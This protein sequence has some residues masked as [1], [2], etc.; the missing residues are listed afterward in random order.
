MRRVI[1]SVLL[2]L[3]LLEGGLRVLLGNFGQSKVLQRSDDAEICLELKPETQLVYTGWRAR[4]APSNMI[5]NSAGFRG[6]ELEDKEQDGPLRMVVLG[7]SF[8][9]GQGVDYEQSY[10]AVAGRSLS[11]AGIE[12]EI[13]NLGVPGHATPQSVALVRARAA[14]LQPDVVL[15]SVFANDLSAAE[16]YCH[17]GKGGNAV[18]A[19]VLRNV[20]VGRLLYLMASPLIAGDV[21]PED[22]PDLATPPERFVSSIQELQVLG[23]EKGFLVAVVLLTDRSMFLEQRFCSDCTP[24]HDLVSKTDAH[25]IDL[26]P[27]WEELQGDIGANFITGEDHFT[28]TGNQQVGA[29]LAKELQS[30]DAL[31]QRAR[32]GEQP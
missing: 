27:V 1:F 22:Y 10:P 17:Y 12:T 26:G 32:G 5:I 9:F 11:E 20:Y 14:E 29:A 19:W 24:A 28:T 4:V 15:L 18:G 3:V 2:G 25:V 6:P 8:T 21:T 23:R 16:S 30:W 7:D 13:L 31:Q